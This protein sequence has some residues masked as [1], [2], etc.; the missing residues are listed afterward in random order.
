[1]SPVSSFQPPLAGQL[2]EGVEGGVEAD[3]E[4]GGEGVTD[5]EGSQ[6]RARSLLL[7]VEHAA[8]NRDTMF[9]SFGNTLF[10]PKREEP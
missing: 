6:A 2:P 3:V 1:M 9:G 10:V 4:W 8:L 7:N 5:N